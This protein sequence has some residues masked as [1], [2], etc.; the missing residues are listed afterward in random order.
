MAEYIER[1]A[2]YQDINDLSK[3]NKSADYRQAVNDCM[4]VLDKQPKADAAEVK[5]GKWIK[6]T[7]MSPPEYHG[8]YVCSECGDKALCKNHR[9]EL[10][11]YCP[12]CGARM[13]G[14][15]EDNATD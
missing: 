10:S 14:K 2:Y 1:E 13:D 8:K 11:I 6:I 4:D 7:G 5:H 3:G 9:E 15:G 12:N